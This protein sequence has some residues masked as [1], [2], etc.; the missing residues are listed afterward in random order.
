M[1]AVV[2]KATVAEFDDEY[3]RLAAQL[4][5]LAFSKY[6]CLDFVS[7]TEGD[8]EI[9]IS[10]WDNEKQI[11]EWKKDP[12]HRLAQE[13]GRNKWYKSYTVEI[14]ELKRAHGK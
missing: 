7:L 1:Y 4:K 10:Y 2:F 5:E 14:M 11:M 13:K 12:A 8:K 9:A 3:F 6:G